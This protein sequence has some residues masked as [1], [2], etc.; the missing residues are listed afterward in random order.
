MTSYCRSQGRATNS[1]DPSGGGSPPQF[2]EVRIDEILDHQHYRQAAARAQVTPLPVRPAGLLTERGLWLQLHLTPV[3][4]AVR[5]DEYVCIGGGSM[6]AL[7]RAMLKPSDVIPV[8]V[9]PEFDDSM[10]PEFIYAESVLLPIF[11]RVD[12]KDLRRV[13]WAVLAIRDNEIARTLANRPRKVDLAR[14]A[15]VSVSYLRP[16]RH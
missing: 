10:L 5:H 1:A 12:R 16:R 4:V 9:W 14:I 11:F 7:V 8:L 13:I 6:L 15:H 2:H 3:H